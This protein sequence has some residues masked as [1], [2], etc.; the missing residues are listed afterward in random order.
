MKFKKALITGITGQDG[1]YLAEFL[2]KK[3]YI[4][5]GI[6][7]KSSSFNTSR[8][9]H[10]YDNEKFKNKFFLH[11]GDLLDPNSLSK[12]IR[13]IEPNEIYNLAAQSHVG[14]SFQL[15]NYTTQVNSIGTL[16]LLQAIKDCG[17][18][19][20]TKFYQASTSELFGEIQEK[21]QSE[22][23]KFYPKS[24][25]ATS[26]LFAYWITKNYRE[27]YKIFASNG[28]LFNHESP[29]RGETFVTRKI[30]IG[31]SKIIYGLEKCL[32]LGN[33]YSLRDWGH[34]KDYVEMC[35]KVLQFKKPDDFVIATEKQ[36]SVKF[37]V[38]QCFKYLGI[39]IK[40]FGK[41][42]N[43][44]AKIIKFNQTKY[45]NLK[46]N[47]TV[48]RIN[49]RYFRP[50]EVNNLIGNANK[51]KKMLKWSPKR[52]IQHLIKE[53][54]DSDLELIKKLYLR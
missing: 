46:K 40:W 24:P 21:R 4:V 42:I 3:K 31:L 28:I 51:A 39:K 5:H 16:N 19:K 52:K 6:K 23:T 17:L 32:Y 27:S 25:Y 44:N 18:S 29:R 13:S 53:M 35:W 54:M 36:Y 14:V 22:K 7:R 26:K 50:N 47:M 1:S 15:P 41:G 43:E 10:I 38:E 8:I 48:V 37:F 11:Y 34:A 49:K 33:I 45:P 30:T 2:L 20:K 12:I 9:D